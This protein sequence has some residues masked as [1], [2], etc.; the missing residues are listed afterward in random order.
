MKKNMGSADRVIRAVLGLAGV[1][2]A[3]TGVSAWGWLGLPLLATAALG[4]C[5]PYALFGWNSGAKD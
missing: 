3:L 5:P 2:I 4:F 1:A